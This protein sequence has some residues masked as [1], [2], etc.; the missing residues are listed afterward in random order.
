LFNSSLAVVLKLL[1]PLICKALL[2]YNKYV[3]YLSFII[4]KTIKKQ[5]QLVGERKIGRYVIF[6]VKCLKRNRIPIV[7]ILVFY[8]GFVAFNY[9]MFAF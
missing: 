5:L 7:V 8:F 1:P 4:I 6:H 9:F 2:I 3:N